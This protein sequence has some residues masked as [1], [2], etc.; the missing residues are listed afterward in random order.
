[1]VLWWASSPGLLALRERVRVRGT[2]RERAIPL[3]PALS[4]REREQI[5]AS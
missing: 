5:E 4:H 1:V 2:H 3:T